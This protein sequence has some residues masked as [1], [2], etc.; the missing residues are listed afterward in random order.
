MIF[1]KFDER[2]RPMDR[3]EPKAETAKPDS[4]K[5]QPIAVESAPQA[6]PV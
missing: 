2:A 4:R 5:P 3:I 1:G 6:Q